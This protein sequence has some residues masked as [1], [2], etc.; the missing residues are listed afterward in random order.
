MNETM[1]EEWL[2][3]SDAAKV[4]GVHPST[5]R[6]W[7]DKGALPTHKT[8]GGHRRYRHSEISLWAEAT[9]RPGNIEPE[10]MMQEVIKTVRMQISEGRLEA[11][12]W[13]KNL[14]EDARAQYRLSGRSLF[15]GLMTYVATKGAEAASEAYAIGYEYASRAHRYRLSYVDATC[16]FLFF[17]NALIESVIKVYSD[18]N[19]PSGQTAEMFQKMHIFTD[20]ILV[21]LLQTHEKLGN[22][23]R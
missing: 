17:R 23:N 2:S 12:S 6:L 16:A 11:E 1:T 19:V 8:Q 20:D 21:S 18:A 5:V 3:L 10:H 7:S 14:D 22:S 13:Y 4:L 9:Y 15:H